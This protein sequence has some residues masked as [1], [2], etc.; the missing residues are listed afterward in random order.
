MSVRSWWVQV[1]SSASPAPVLHDTPLGSPHHAM[2]RDAYDSDSDGVDSGDDVDAFDSDA[3]GQPLCTEVCD[4]RC[5][6]FI[7]GARCG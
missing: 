6:S 1:A 4:G 5:D 2:V 3:A 7:R